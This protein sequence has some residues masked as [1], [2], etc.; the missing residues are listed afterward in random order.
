MQPNEENRK[1]L[2]SLGGFNI[3]KH[4]EGDEEQFID[5]TKATKLFLKHNHSR[6][7]KVH[8]L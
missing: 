4:N 3:K 2:I 1:G 6:I 8:L 5:G 7:F